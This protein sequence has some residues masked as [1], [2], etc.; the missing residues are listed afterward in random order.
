VLYHP[1]AMRQTIGPMRELIA[2]MGL[3]PSYADERLEIYPVPAVPAPRP[4]IYLGAGWGG[5]E[6]DGERTWRWMRERAELY[7]VNPTGQTRSVRLE[8]RMESYERERPLS[9]A[10]GDAPP[11][12]I[13]VSRAAMSRTVSLLLPPGTHVVYLG[14]P[15]DPRPGRG[16]EPISISFDRIAVR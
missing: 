7:L 2:E 10:L 14:A 1:D 9:L 16:A 3:A 11:A 8:L 6:R 15:A 5:V 12:T 13:P 4:L